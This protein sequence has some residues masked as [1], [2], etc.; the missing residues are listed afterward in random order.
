MNNFV[1][2]VAS[3]GLTLTTTVW[4]SGATLLVPVVHAQSS[5][6]L[7]SQIAALL[8]QIQALQ[9]QLNTAKGGSSSSYSFT[10]DLTV[11][12]KGDDVNALQQVLIDGGYLKV[13]APTGFFGP[14]T[15]AALAAWQSAAGVSPAAGY[16]GPKSR[17]AFAAAA[18]SYPTP[19]PG[20]PTPGVVPASGLVVSLASDSP[21][22]S[23]IAGAGQVA[24][25]KWMFTA[26][27]SSPATLSAM[28]FK[29][30]GVVSDSNINNLYLANADGAII[31]QYSSLSRGLAS[32]SGLNISVG[33]GQTVYL[34]LRM[35]LSS[36]ATSGQSNGWTL[37]SVTAGGVVVSGLP[38]DSKILAVTS[39]SNPSIASVTWN[40][41]SVGSTVDAGTTNVL[42]GSATVTV[43]NSSVWLKSVKYGLVGSANMA[44]V[45]NLRLL[46][47]GNQIGS[48]LATA[49]SDGSAV[50]DLSGSPVR[51]SV[52]NSTV[53]VYADIMG[54][55][56]RNLTVR[57][58]RPYDLYFVDSEY[59]TGISPTVTDDSNQI[60]IN[61]GQI[62]VS[63]ASDTPTGNVPIGAANVTLGK[64]A[65]YAAGEPVKVKF[66]DLRIA[67]TGAADFSSSTV[68]T[69][70][71]E[72]V[73]LI[74]DVGG[75]V[76]STVSTVA[77]GTG[78]GQCTLAAANVTCHLG[79]SSSPINYIIPANSTRVL[80]ARV[81]ILST[82]AN[83]TALTASLPAMTSNLE[84]QISFQAGNSGTATGAALTISTTP[85]TVA[86]NGS[87][88]NPTFVAGAN[89]SKVASF[90]LTASAAESVKVSTITI[91]KDSN[92]NFDLQSLKLMVG[93][94]QF[95]TTR[96]TIGDAETG[97]SFS[98]SSP[99]T[100]PAGGSVTVDV[101]A[102]I[103]TST[104]AAT[105]T[106]T[107]D[108][109]SLTAT[110]VT[111]NS[112]V[113]SPAATNGQ[114]IV[115]SSG[116]TLTIAADSAT[117]SSQYIVMGSADNSVFS[118]RLTANNVEDI[119]VTDLAFLDTIANNTAGR[120]SFNNM[121]LYD[122]STL[123]AGPLTPTIGGTTTSTV[124]FSF[125]NTPV[126]VS[127]SNSKT[128]LVKGD[129]GSFDA[130][131]VS[132]SGHVWSINAT[133]TDVTS[134]G[135][136]SNNS[137][138]V[139]F[140]GTVGGNAMKVF[141]T[142]LSFTSSLIGATT[143]RSRAA[144][145]D[146]ATVNWTA[147]SAYQAILGTVSV[148]FNGLAASAGST[149]FTVDLLKS[150]GTAM[151]SA[152]QQTCTPGAGNSCSVTFGPQFTL[153]AGSTQASKIR[154][155]SASFFN[156]ASTGESLSVLI[157]AVGDVA[158][159]DG[160]T[161][162][163]ALET[164]TVPFTVVNVSYE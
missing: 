53:D 26:G 101:F 150:D 14:M 88:Q 94:S 151:G 74:D 134:Y 12:S 132:N 135:R 65:I 34:T 128:L 45:R 21:A 39:V 71:I 9:S 120:T 112:S 164:S 125:G 25:G 124:T 24:V 50:F 28:T 131:A 160:S 133:S 69:A 157:N 43:S 87:Y 54:S 27:A 111:S 62:T 98:G 52:G 33:A 114:D 56:N 18:P 20:Y 99:I 162:G 136:D 92:A 57:T 163:I 41:N 75:Q 5:A 152:S 159:D 105:H 149:A 100:V 102:D 11:G 86:A 51:V 82:I 23:A 155:N 138:T 156:Q 66:L 126:I 158:W 48:T 10:R 129:V 153:S 97:L 29:K 58:L 16:F 63:K 6:D 117:P 85:L 4:L 47:N 84:G 3:V 60:S 109:V 89:N 154:V 78:N 79:T 59:N 147:N 83:V 139:S 36:S 121:K 122:G 15:K 140:S 146:L 46:V 118:I 67:R 19:T 44:D 137:A 148:K 64:F 13:A 110:G 81:N 107:I 141:R 76:G 106:S 2:K 40:Y 77:S 130:G 72:N 55:P 70:S 68:V 96:P 17:A 31:A 49:G 95:G 7:Q 119:K 104:S 37:D 127:K 144:V 113:T 73:Q 30:I 103:L 123:I 91:D 145:D 116:P 142:K 42:L 35:D 108:Y 93:S 115:I 161:A 8:A 90:V 22:G 61:Q 38:S 80:S 1:R 143:A 32:F